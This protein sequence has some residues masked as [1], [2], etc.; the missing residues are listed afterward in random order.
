MR[1]LRV[2]IDTSVFGGMFDSEFAEDTRAFFDFVD[3][4]RFRLAISENVIKEITLAPDRV[5]HFFDAY[6]TE[7]DCFMD[8][9]EIQR[10][11]DCYL[12]S[13]V[14]TY[15]SWADASYVAYATVYSCAGLVSWNY[16]HI[17]HKEKSMLFNVVNVSQG[18]QP[19]FI[20]TPKEVM[21]HA[22]ER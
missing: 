14:L 8:S 7:M 12:Q 10:L 6:R 1:P 19:L 21:S 13:K 15:K 9:L 17:V 18:Y 16:K 11:T 3:K 22:Q 20:A 4:G 5:K 2:F